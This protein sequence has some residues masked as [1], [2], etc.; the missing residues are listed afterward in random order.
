MKDETCNQFFRWRVSATYHNYLHLSIFS[1][2][3]RDLTT[4]IEIRQEM[5]Q[6]QM[7]KTA[8]LKL[9]LD[10][11]LRATAENDCLLRLKTLG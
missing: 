8:A 2:Q 9:S 4:Q 11:Y 6:L 7:E 1:A 10:E 3:S 5:A